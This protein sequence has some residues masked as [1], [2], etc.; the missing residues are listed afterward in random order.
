[1][2]S[3]E[4]GG[5]G[6][7]RGRGCRRSGGRGGS[8]GCCRGETGGGGSSRGRHGVS[9]GLGAPRAG[10]QPQK[11][12]GRRVGGDPAVRA[13]RGR[14]CRFPPGVALPCRCLVVASSSSLF[15]LHLILSARA[16]S[17]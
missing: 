1:M 3:Q 16:R 13:P 10:E 11:G 8:S 17:V 12:H 15:I 5:E 2:V 14:A 9:G 6:E 7:G 4:G